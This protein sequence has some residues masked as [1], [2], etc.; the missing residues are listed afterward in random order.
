[1][2]RQDSFEFIKL[3]QEGKVAIVTFSRPEVLN[4]LHP[5]LLAEL[6]RFLASVN[7]D[8]EINAIVLTGEGR[9]FSA[10]GDLK[11]LFQEAGGE[12]RGWGMSWETI[13]RLR[14]LLSTLLSVEQPIIAAVNGPA[15]GAAAN[16]ALLCDVVIAADNARFGDPHVRIGAT[17]GD[18]GAVIWPML[19]GVSKAKELLMTGDL[20]DAQEANRIGLVNK[21]VPLEELM[22]TA[23]SLAH[24]LAEGPTLAIRYTKM[25]INKHVIQSLNLVLDF[26]ISSECLTTTT[27]DHREGV[28]AF[29]QKREP[30]FQGR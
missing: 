6:E 26:S 13:R 8:Q 23:L 30:S 27:E 28:A 2:E 20:V 11:D 1:M 7:E 5:P 15:I 14:R 9:A 29:V 19:V 12:P 22:P 25:A 21:V 10:G 18:G 24:R 17:A 4:A 3:E 16:L